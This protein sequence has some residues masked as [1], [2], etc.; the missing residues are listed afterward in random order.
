MSGVVIVEAQAFDAAL[1]GSD[2]IPT[3]LTTASG[4]FQAEVSPDR[5][6]LIYRLKIEGMDS[7]LTD[8]DLHFGQTG[9]NG[10][11]VASLCG[12]EVRACPVSG[13]ILGVLKSTDVQGA[14][15][16]GLAPEDMDAF[17]RALSEESLY[18]TVS[19]RHFPNGELRGQLVASKHLP[20]P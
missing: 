19:S 18:V 11:V 8:V 13:E 9:V 6:S 7:P 12:G 20:P 16:Q 3:V 1:R 10:G 4:G 5:S 17:M 14:V 15:A 2:Q